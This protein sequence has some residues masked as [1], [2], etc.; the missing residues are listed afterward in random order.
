MRRLLLLLFVAACA[1]LP[2]GVLA[3]RQRAALQRRDWLTAVQLGRARVA[4]APFDL[5]ARY[6][7]ACALA[8]AGDDAAA[9]RTLAEAIALGYDDAGW[10]ERD[11]DLQSLR[12]RAELSALS[13]EARRVTR[14][15]ISVPG[16]RVLIRE[17]LS[18]PIRLRLP[19][20]TPP[21]SSARADLTAHPLSE[22]TPPRADLG[23][24]PRSGPPAPGRLR[25][26]L[27]LHPS[28][29]RLN[30]QLERLAPVLLR[31]GFAL[32]VPMYPRLEGWNDAELTSLLDSTVPALADVLDVEH[33]LLLGLSAGAEA[34][35]VAWAATPRRFLAV[36]ASAPPAELFGGATPAGR[37]LRPPVA[38]PSGAQASPVVLFF[39][40]EDPALTAWQTAL[41]GWRA[42]GLPFSTRVFAGRDHELLFD[43]ALLEAELAAL[44]PVSAGR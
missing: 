40:S 27:W 1:P 34:A 23:A 18:T 5:G 6:D 19:E 8:R 13:A 38:L 35:L 39:G 31:H 37:P 10:L 41:P 42:R 44:P 21:G 14:E 26:A 11:E 4:R 12:A 20:A 43:E 2:P 3:A 33:P 9:L 22:A 17:T 30:P 25:L 15:G 16:T 32:A 36:W 29:A 7:L 24:R 28:G